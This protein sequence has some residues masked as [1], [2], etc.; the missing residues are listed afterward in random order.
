MIIIDSHLKYV[1]LTSIKGW[2]VR[3]KDGLKLK[4]LVRKIA[5]NG[6]SVI[7]MPGKLK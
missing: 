1:K 3:R 4:L 5:L 6:F 7:K 2:K